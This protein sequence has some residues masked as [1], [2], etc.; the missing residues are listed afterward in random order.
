MSR[1]LAICS[2]KLFFLT[3]SFFSLTKC[4]PDSTLEQPEDR[5]EIGSGNNKEAC[6]KDEDNGNVTFCR[7]LKIATGDTGALG[8]GCSSKDMKADRRWV[9]QYVCMFEFKAK[10]LRP[11]A[12]A[13]QQFETYT[14]PSKAIEGLKSW[15]KEKGRKIV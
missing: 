1:K 11:S 3:P 15:S 8:M 4:L 12:L 2:P 13:L 10:D 6:N 9:T 14:V 7:R 5:R